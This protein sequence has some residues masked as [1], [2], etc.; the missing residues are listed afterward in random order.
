MSEPAAV[1]PPQGMLW[2]SRIEVPRHPVLRATWTDGRT[3]D[4][5]FTEVIARSKWFATLTFPEA[6]RDVEIIFGGSGV[7]WAS[8]ADFCAQALRRLAEE[9]AGL[10]EKEGA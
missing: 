3:M 1:E 2:L 9:Q 7:Q 10:R 8:N 6:F 4:V 5:D